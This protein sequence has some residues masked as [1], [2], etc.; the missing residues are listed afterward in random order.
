MVGKQGWREVGKDAG[1]QPV[2]R[3]HRQGRME[4]Q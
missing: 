3:E 4:K 2:V 1:R